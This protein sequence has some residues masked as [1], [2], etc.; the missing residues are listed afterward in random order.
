MHGKDS[1]QLNILNSIYTF[2]SLIFNLRPPQ[3]STCFVHLLDN[4]PCTGVNVKI[5]QMSFRVLNT[6]SAWWRRYLVITRPSLLRFIFHPQHQQYSLFLSFVRQELMFNMKDY[7]VRNILQ[8]VQITR[9]VKLMLL[10]LPH[11]RD[12]WRFLDFQT[13]IYFASRIMFI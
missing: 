2:S 1:E 7:V 3:F 10:F 9:F 8:I 4:T 13:K 12:S 11:P 5:I 6:V